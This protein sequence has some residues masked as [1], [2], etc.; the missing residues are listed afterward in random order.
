MMAF[1]RDHPFFG[2][3]ALLSHRFFRTE[4]EPEVMLILDWKSREEMQATTD[5]ELSTRFRAD[6]SPLLGGAPK[7]AHDPTGLPG[8]VGPSSDGRAD[9]VLQFS[10]GYPPVGPQARNR[11]RG[12]RTRRSE[13]DEHRRPG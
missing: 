12:H 5:N 11:R 8:A 7:L 2:Q 4:G 3:E 6:L 13:R 9:F 1:M 10:C